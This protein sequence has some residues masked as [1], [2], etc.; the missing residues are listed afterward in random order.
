MLSLN[1]KKMEVDKNI[2][3]DGKE[4]GDGLKK[5]G[6]VEIITEQIVA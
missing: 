3:N 1:Q 4:L 6:E 5:S 2:S